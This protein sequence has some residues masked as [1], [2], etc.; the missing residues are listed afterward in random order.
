MFNGFA[1]QKSI[2][3]IEDIERNE[4]ES[5]LGSVDEIVAPFLDDFPDYVKRRAKQMARYYEI[6]YLL[7][8]KLR[9]I[10]IDT[11]YDEYKDDWWD[12]HVPDDVKSYVKNL[13]NKEGDLGVSLRSKRD[14][15]FTTF[16]HLVDIIRSNKDVVGVRFTSVNALQ[17]ILAVLNN[18]RGP[19]AHNT[20]LA[21]DE[22]ARL[23]V[24]I[25][26]LFRLIRR[27]YTPA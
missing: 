3:L 19:I 4:L 12:L 16:G 24:A 27:T 2:D 21:P 15:D 17:R 5:P 1:L 6:F 26:D 10:I 25:R 11:M 9:S 22:V 13:Q 14:I 20:V 23:Y 7:E 8:D 18:V